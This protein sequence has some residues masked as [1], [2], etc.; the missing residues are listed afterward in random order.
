MVDPNSVDDQRGLVRI[1]KL[2]RF[3]LGGIGQYEVAAALAITYL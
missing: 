3:E 1:P 2:A